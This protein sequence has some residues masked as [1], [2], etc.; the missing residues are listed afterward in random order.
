MFVPRVL[1]HKLP[2]DEEMNSVVAMG[3]GGGGAAP[4]CAQRGHNPLVINL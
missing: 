2:E 4:G 1:Y 3:G